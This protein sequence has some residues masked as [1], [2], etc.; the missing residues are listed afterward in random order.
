MRS[1]KITRQAL[2][3]AG[4]GA[5]RGQKLDCHYLVLDTGGEVRLAGRGRLEKDG[6]FAINFRGKLPPG[7]YAVLI[8]L[9]LNGNTV[10]PDIRRAELHI[11]AER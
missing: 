6:T 11:P 10:N 5:L 1:Y 3:D 8:T 4:Q 7:G 9:Y 2:Q